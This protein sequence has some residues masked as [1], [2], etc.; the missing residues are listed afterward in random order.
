LEIFFMSK[1]TLW[2][3]SSLARE[4]GRNFRT[5]AKALS[6]VKADGKL[7]GKPA[8]HMANCIAVLEQLE[9]R[10]GRVQQRA[11]PER[12]DPVLERQIH[13]IES[14]SEE[15]ATLLGKLRSERTVEARRAIVKGGGAKCVGALQRSLTS[16][17]GSGSDAFLRELFVREQ[18]D[19]VM[20]EILDLCQWTIS[21]QEVSK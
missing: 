6:G 14:A 16:T 18:M 9:H 4:T 2:S 21:P 15:V 8:W 19:F 10:T 3:I 13:A 7:A 1:K 5:V 12:F 17:I 20:S 11:V